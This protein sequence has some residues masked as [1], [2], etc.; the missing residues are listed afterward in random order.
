MFFGSCPNCTSLCK[1][2]IFLYI[3]RLP[4]G[5]HGQAVSSS[6][7]LSRP[8]LKSA[9]CLG[10]HLHD[11]NHQSPGGPSSSTFSINKSESSE[12][13]KLLLQVLASET[14]QLQQN[15]QPKGNAALLGCDE[16]YLSFGLWLPPWLPVY[17]LLLLCQHKQIHVRRNSEQKFTHPHR[18]SQNTQ[19]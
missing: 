1:L 2:P 4:Q 10:M 14:W 5:T 11:K 7:A 15:M 19:E 12:L 9:A 18:I 16:E 3:W 8:F 6:V 17:W 13:P